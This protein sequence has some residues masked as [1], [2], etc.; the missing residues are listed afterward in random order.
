VRGECE[1]DRD[2]EGIDTQ[3]MFKFIHNDVV[4]ERM[5]PTLDLNCEENTV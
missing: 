5:T 2:L 3:S 1:I 4:L